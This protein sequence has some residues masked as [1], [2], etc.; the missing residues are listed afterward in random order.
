MSAD[1]WSFWTQFLVLVLL[2]DSFKESE[3][4]DHF[5]NLIYL[6]GLCLWHNISAVDVG[7][8]RSGFVSWVDQ[9]SW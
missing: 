2:W 3:C 1:M 8:I 9:F 7:V 6:F 5:I 4:Y